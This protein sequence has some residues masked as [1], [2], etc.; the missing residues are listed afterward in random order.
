MTFTGYN[1]VSAALDAFNA[2][3]FSKGVSKSTLY[4]IQ[5]N[6]NSVATNKETASY[7]VMGSNVSALVGDMVAISGALPLTTAYS[8]DKFHYKY[9]G[10]KYNKGSATGTFSILWEQKA[11][12]KLSY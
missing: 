9:I 12:A 3:E 8:A 2:Q 4:S 6:H 11:I 10:I 5:V 1:S 7:E